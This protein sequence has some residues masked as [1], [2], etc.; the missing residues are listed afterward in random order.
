MD[1]VGKLRW[2]GSKDQQD[3]LK[4]QK[5]LNRGGDFKMSVSTKVCSNHFAAGYR[6]DQCTTSTLYLNGYT[7]LHEIKKRKLP[8]KRKLLAASSPPPPKRA[9]SI[10]RDG[11]DNLNNVFIVEQHEDHIYEVEEKTLASRFTPIT[12]CNHCIKLNSKVI[13]LKKMLHEKEK[14]LEKLNSELEGSKIQKKEQSNPLLSYSEVEDNDK[15]L[16]FYTGLQN[17]KVFEWMMNKIKYKIAKLQY[18]QGKK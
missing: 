17:E 2:Y 4:W 14:Q 3:I 1:H 12:A 5:L 6:S 11:S 18:Y 10:K 9:R 13:D 8:S 16:K 15:M 7:H